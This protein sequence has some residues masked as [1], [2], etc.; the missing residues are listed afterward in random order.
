MR[1]N[2]YLTFNG[3]CEA[4]LRFYEKCLGGKI[5]MMMTYGDSPM[6]GQA[7]PDWRSKILHTTLE[8]GSHLLQGADVLPGS[9]QKPQGF[10]VLLNVNTAAEADRIFAT[11]AEKGVV[12]IPI[13]ETFW[14]PRFGVLVDQFDTP[15]IISCK[16]PA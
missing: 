5:V 16:K 2:P 13:Q 9:Y 11:L 8:V 7:P 15:W 1:L 10:S 14:A 12:Q 3:Q 6:A 4:A